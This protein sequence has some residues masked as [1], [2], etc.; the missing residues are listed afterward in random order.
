MGYDS[1]LVLIEV[2]V[3]NQLD[4]RPEHRRMMQA[5]LN[6]PVQTEGRECTESEDAALLEAVGLRVDTI[7]PTRAP[8][9]LNIV[10]IRPA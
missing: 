1:R 4:Q 7:V 6:M 3:P 9:G 2:V 10:E 8:L 5:D